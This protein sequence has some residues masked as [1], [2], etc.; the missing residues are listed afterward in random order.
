M[1]DKCDRYEAGTGLRNP[2]NSRR[3]PFS[4]EGCVLDVKN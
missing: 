1:E 3:A 4:K 2:K